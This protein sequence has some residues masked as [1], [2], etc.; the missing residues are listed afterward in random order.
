MQK[1]KIL[2]IILV[3]LGIIIAFSVWFFLQYNQIKNQA[4]ILGKPINTTSSQTSQTTT[5]SLKTYRN[6]QYGFEFQYPEDWSFYPN[7]FSSPFSKFNLIGASLEENSIPD[8]ITPSIVINIVTPDFAD[9]TS[10]SF[11]KLNASTSII[12]VAGVKVTKYEYEFENLPRIAVVSLPLDKYRML[13]GASKKYEDVFN[14]MIL[15]FKFTK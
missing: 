10:M 2:V 12:I 6:E 8:P 7:T 5:S 13:L 14:Q 4:Q 1:N 9:R 15:T 11:K 3:A